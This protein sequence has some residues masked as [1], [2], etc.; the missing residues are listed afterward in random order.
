MK[1]ILF[2][3]A[4]LAT[5]V[6]AWADLSNL[7]RIADFSIPVVSWTG[8]TDLSSSWAPTMQE[9]FADGDGTEWTL[10][11]RYATDVNSIT[12]WYYL[13]LNIA[14]SSAGSPNYRYIYTPSTE[15]FLLD[16]AAVNEQNNDDY[17]WGFVGNPVDGFKLYNA[18]SK[19]YLGMGESAPVFSADGQ[20]WTLSSSN[21]TRISGGF[22]ISAGGKRLGMVYTTKNILGYNADY[23]D[24][25]S[26]FVVESMPKVLQVTYIFKYGDKEYVQT[27]SVNEG[28][29]YPEITVKFPFGLS[30]SKPKGNVSSADATNGVITKPIDLALN[31]PFKYAADANSI[32][33][34]YYLKLNIAGSSAGSPNYR[35][36]YTP[37]TEGFLL[38]KA[39]V[40]EQNNDDYAWGFVGNPVDGFKL[41]NAKSKQYLGMGESAPVFS[42]D[43]QVWTLSSSNDTRIS[44]GFT[45]SAGGKRLGMVYI[46][47]GDPGYNVLGYNDEYNDSRSS[48]VVETMDFEN[49]VVLRTLIITT[50]ALITDLGTGTEVGCVT[51]DSRQVLSTALTSAEKSLATMKDCAE[52]A[53]ALQAAIDALE[54]IQP[55]PSKYYYIVSAFETG[56]RKYI[57]V[58]NGGEMQYD[59]LGS[60]ASTAIGRVFTFADAGNGMMYLRNVE[61]GTYLSSASADGEQE[62]VKATDNGIAV[63]ISNLGKDNIVK[64]VPE[65]GDMLY[66]SA[67]GSVVGQNKEGVDSE[68]AW[69]I[70]EIGNVS[71]L[72]HPVTIG[73]TRWATMI[74][75]YDAV[76]P[77]GVK[78]YVVSA[79]STENVNMDE[80][81]SDVIPANTAVLLEADAKT[82][83]FK[84]STKEPA[85]RIPHVKGWTGTVFDEYIVPENDEVAYKMFND[86]GTARFFKVALEENEDVDGLSFRNR[87]FTSYMLLRSTSNSARS[88][89]IGGSVETSIENLRGADNVTDVT[90]Y[91]LSGRRVQNVGSGLYIVNGKKVVK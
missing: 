64:I 24:S 22:T 3:F 31:L 53:Q 9:A 75:G 38:D 7:P 60:D 35:Y 55:D 74:L 45:I 8:A 68:I 20:V 51:T 67:D 4:M 44:G 65:G 6:A 29:A 52:N 50:K 46:K 33:D 49:A 80:V 73:A 78:A 42:A 82:Y 62:M 37:S 58:N 40:N 27:T 39:A 91:D 86:N 71:A 43:G 54:T 81:L 41:Y 16:K 89:G 88:I 28:D 14:G 21:D 90:T 36:I 61:R 1:K 5:T 17:A 59:A 57:H 87:A 25:R 2:T 66:A 48:F 47:N 69:Q 23:N 26:T 83:E 15:G 19:Q 13:K 70:V 85:S 10:P 32:T 18:K 12:D 79:F 84:L 30:A 56:N 76:I 63:Q 77:E 11:F 34:W 72:S